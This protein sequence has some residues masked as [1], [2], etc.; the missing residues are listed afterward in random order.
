MKPNTAFWLLSIFACLILH[1]NAADPVNE[2]TPEQE[3]PAKGLELHCTPL[4]TKLNYG[5]T[6]TIVCVVTNTTDTF[7]PLSNSDLHYCLV[8]EGD[9]WHTGQVPNI[10]AHLTDR[11]EVEPAYW[12]QN[13]YIPP[14]S[15]LSMEFTVIASELGK[16][17]GKIV[18]DPVVHGG[19]IFGDDAL[20]KAKKACVYS[21]DIEFNVVDP[22]TLQ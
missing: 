2:T 19:G 11:I 3:S 17:K 8:K 16:F 22:G 20:E 1:A 9:P 6:V 5:G 10:T 21:N 15:C 12:G 13:L 14:H 18:Y 7:K 4:P